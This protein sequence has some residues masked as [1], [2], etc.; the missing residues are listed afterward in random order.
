MGAPDDR[1]GLTHRPRPRGWFFD[2]TAGRHTYSARI[3]DV[4]VDAAWASV[5][6]S[7]AR[8]LDRGGVYDWARSPGYRIRYRIRYR[9][10]VSDPPTT[11]PQHRARQ[12]WSV[13]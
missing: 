13:A 11:W 4:G 1:R 8:F 2:N 10:P 5:G 12:S 3:L 6:F 7:L 9:I